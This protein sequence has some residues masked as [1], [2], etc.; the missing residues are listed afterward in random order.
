LRNKSAI[1]PCGEAAPVVTGLRYAKPLDG[2]ALGMMAA[3]AT[4][5]VIFVL[6]RARAFGDTPYYVDSILKYGGGRDLLF[7][8]FGHLLW[9]P[10]VWLLFRLSA[11]VAPGAQDPLLVLRIS[12]ALNLAAGL[13]CVLLAFRIS[14]HF[15]STSMAVLT[16]SAV[17]VSQ[18]V[19]DYSH[20][21]TAYVPGLLFLFLGL[22]L[23]LSETRS[24]ESAR[25]GGCAVF[26]VALACAVLMWLPYMFALPAL[27]SLPLLYGFRGKQSFLFAFRSTAVCALAGFLAYAAVGIKLHI[28]SFADFAAWVSGSS[29]GLA[30]VGGLPRAVFGFARCF[31]NLDNDGIQFRRFLLHDPYSHV[32]ALGLVAA[33]LWKIALIYCLALVLCWRLVRGSE[34]DRRVCWFLLL[35]VAP[36]FLF[37]LKWY[38][39]DMERYMAVLPALAVAASCALGA[40]PSWLARAAGLLL[41]GSLFVVNLAHYNLW[42]TRNDARSLSTRINVLG[43]VPEG[44]YLVV[45]PQD[46]LEGLPPYA[47][48]LET[49]RTRAMDVSAVVPIA[50]SDAADWKGIFARNA[51]RKWQ[52][53]KQVWVCQGFFDARPETKW[54]WVEGAEGGVRWTD[55]HS[56]FAQLHTGKIRG[57]FMEVPG[58]D[59]N[60]AFLRAV[61]AGT[62]M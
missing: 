49:V 61:S 33:G 56:F 26:G 36:V 37:A 14:R 38:G 5:V 44:S 62:P 20:A 55:L 8:D 31:F 12:Q 57:D 52:E 45:F 40:H 17:A 32:S 58:T 30:A 11:V 47:S 2:M 25:W 7:W 10:L 21:G 43:S 19:L 27:L 18:A 23:F 29:H 46:P 34:L 4:Y 59:A 39:G 50:Y 42:T 15:T 35:T 16:A 28:L 1:P 54:G 6:T 53:G 48:G 9:R 51:I 24:S 41:L 13:G 60:V 22:D 3:G